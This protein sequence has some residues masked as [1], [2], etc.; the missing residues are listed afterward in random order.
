LVDT[1][2]YPKLNILILKNIIEKKKPENFLENKVLFG[3]ADNAISL[4][5]KSK[6]KFNDFLV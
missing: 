1:A 2:Q 5:F 4:S 6:Y 3:L